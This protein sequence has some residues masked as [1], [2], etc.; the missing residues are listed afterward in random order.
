MPH[1]PYA[2]SDD[3]E[4][5]HPQSGWTLLARAITLDNWLSWRDALPRDHPRRGCL[6]TAAAANIA[7]LAE[8]IHAVHRRFPDYRS[9]G[10]TPFRVAHWWDPSEESERHDGSV[11]R[12]RIENFTSQDIVQHAAACPGIR[13]D[14]ATGL[15]VDA[16]LLSPEA[17]PSDRPGPPQSARNPESSPCSRKRQTPRPQTP[18]PSPPSPPPGPG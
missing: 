16:I 15:Y 1:L 3:D 13:L 7:A 2:F 6:T 4:F 12:F 5:L 14:I 10:D 11:C 17:L 8:G 9:L 18:A